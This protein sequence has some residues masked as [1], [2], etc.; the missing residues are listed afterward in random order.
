[1]EKFPSKQHSLSL[2]CMPNEKFYVFQ[3]DTFQKR[4][5]WAHPEFFLFRVHLFLYFEQWMGMFGGRRDHLNLSPLVFVW[6]PF[7]RHLT[8]MINLK[9][10][11]DKNV[12]Q[13]EIY[14]RKSGLSL[15]S[16]GFVV[17]GLL[18]ISVK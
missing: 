7:R 5:N 11:K 10:E 3:H 18:M 6:D 4:G 14:S 16:T 8:Y 9:K 2:L 12:I 13:I 17:K 15:T 1:M